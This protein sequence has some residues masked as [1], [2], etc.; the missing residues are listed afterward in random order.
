MQEAEDIILSCRV[1]GGKLYFCCTY[2][3]RFFSVD[4]DILCCFWKGANEIK[5]KRN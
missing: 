3:S 4:Y 1:V 2:L 5:A